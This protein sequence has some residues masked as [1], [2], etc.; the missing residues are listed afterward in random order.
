MKVFLPFLAA[1]LIILPIVACA[2]VEIQ[3]GEYW[4]LPDDYP[5]KSPYG[6]IFEIWQPEV[7]WRDNTDIVSIDGESWKSLNPAEDVYKWER[8]DSWPYHYSLDE[9]EEAGKEMLLF[10]PITTLPWGWAVPQWVF[11]KCEA[12]GTPI[13]TI[14]IDDGYQEDRDAVA[15]WEDCPKA[16]LVKFIRSFVRYKNNPTFRYAYMATF[17]WGEFGFGKTTMDAAI[18][19]GLTGEVMQSFCKDYTDAWVYALGPD[20][21]VWEHFNKWPRPSWD[22]EGMRDATGWCSDYAINVIGTN[23]R[24]GTGSLS[25]FVRYDYM[26]HHW[27][28]DQYLYAPTIHEIGKDGVS[29]FGNEFTEGPLGIYPDFGDYTFFRLAM[30][31]MI[32][33][34]VNY[35]TYGAMNYELLDA[36][37]TYHP[38]FAALRDYFR[39]SAGYP[40][41]E[42][43][44]AWAILLMWSDYDQCY[45]A[46]GIQPKNFEK[47]LT[48]REV[49]P[50]GNTVLVEK[51]N[52]PDNK[53]GFCSY[54]ESYAYQARRTD[55]A[56]GNDY[57][58]FNLSEEFLSAEE[59]SVQISVYYKD[60]N[61]ANWRIEYNSL[62]DDYEQTPGVSNAGDGEWKSAIFTITDA[63]FRNAQTGGMDFRI[64]N[65]G[66][67][68]VTVS[69]VRVIR[70][71]SAEPTCQSEGYSCCD[72]PCHSG[73][74]S[75]LDG[76]CS[77]ARVC[78]DTC[79]TCQNQDYECCDSCETGT[80]HP[81]LDPDCPGQVCCGA[82]YTPPLP[83]EHNY[84][85]VRTA[86]PPAIDGDI[87]EFSKA[88]PIHVTESQT[89]TTGTYRLMWDDDA[90]YIAAE[91]S[92]EQI[93]AQH[94]A[95]DSS[96]WEDDSLEI[97]FDTLYDKG[98]SLR[99]DDYKFF[100]NPHNAHMDSKAFASSWNSSLSSEVA[101]TGTLNQNTD[102]DTGYVIEAMIPWWIA[103]PVVGDSWGMNMQL[104]DRTASGM[105]STQWS[106]SGLGV[107]VPDGWNNAI[108]T[109]RADSSGD[110]CIEQP[111]L[112]SFI[113]YWKYDS[114][115]YPMSEMME[116]ITLYYAPGYWCP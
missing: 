24:A 76:T 92:D 31:N 5:V 72:A 78:C 82:C 16:E 19:A 33:G 43:P 104:N 1:L 37:E 40:V 46:P 55:H 75:S 69:S 18:D 27:D 38:E 114:T 9:I 49:S 96:L 105:S 86:I 2:Q 3:E 93:N 7:R 80:E 68:D 4:G 83:G 42:A 103:S 102:T 14:D 99:Q 73:P 108:F 88:D 39:Q 61:S 29:F 67:E 54:R 70:L 36:N 25:Q 26:D 66:S 60:D 34:G 115:G 11:D 59:N 112:M 21:L 90:L 100:V 57:I 35:P 41:G 65:G 53:P 30:L 17:V 85:I 77:G 23:V 94:T 47:F 52:W 28:E 84:S 89:G 45:G 116:A 87:S 97:M 113:E 48:Q 64:Y 106:G 71:G 50:N 91:F 20:K 110:G 74:H 79:R 62:S 101:V 56:S 95:N 32:R 8:I 51:H 109:V 81:G 22:R 98:G 13:T 63:D 10:M 44:D 15:V 111:E 6:G 12:Q 107:N 58:Y